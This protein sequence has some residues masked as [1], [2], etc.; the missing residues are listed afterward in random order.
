MAENAP[1][2][3]VRCPKC[4]WQSQNR[5]ICD[6]CGAIFAKVRQREAESDVLESGLLYRHENATYTE[7]SFLSS[8]GHIL[9]LLLIVGVA[10]GFGIRYSR[11]GAPAADESNVTQ[12]SDA[13]FDG[14]T[15]RDKGVWV[16]DFWAPWCGPCREFGPIL[17][18]FANENVGRVSVGKVNVDEQGLVAR[19]FS[20]SSIPTVMVFKDG[21][22]KGRYNG[23]DKEALEATVAPFLK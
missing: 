19:A 7:P 11:H 23:M 20:V 9:A 10:I 8:Y 22:L 18:E 4:G 12:L 13:F 5:E 21:E 1:T 15:L 16:V 17:A 6:S 3:G 2:P 14:T